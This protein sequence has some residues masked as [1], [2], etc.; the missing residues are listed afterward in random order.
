M[1]EVDWLS[2]TDPQAM[3]AFLRDSGKLS[4]RKARLF[5]AACCRRIWH[6]LTD[7]RSRRAVEVAEGF[8]DGRGSREELEA[9]QMG[10]EAASTLLGNYA[11]CVYMYVEYGDNTADEVWR[12]ATA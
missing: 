8:A 6:L 7:E 5:A 9:A 4:G 3:L 1:N 2:C 10:A 11:E 12:A